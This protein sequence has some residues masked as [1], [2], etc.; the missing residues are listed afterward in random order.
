MGRGRLVEPTRAVVFLTYF[1]CSS[2]SRTNLHLLDHHQFHPE[3]LKEGHHPQICSN[4][5]SQQC[6]HGFE[7]R[8][9]P[10]C[11]GVCHWSRELW[12]APTRHRGCMSQD[13]GT[14]LLL[15]SEGDTISEACIHRCPYRQKVCTRVS[16]H[17]HFLCMTP[18]VIWV[19]IRADGLERKTK[20]SEKEVMRQLLRLGRT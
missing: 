20:V 15:Y 2:Y 7:V 14:L 13:G 8:G 3:R 11:C 10:P 19:I 18:T 5:C 9:N 6:P 1:S 12:I 17:D 4:M 16:P